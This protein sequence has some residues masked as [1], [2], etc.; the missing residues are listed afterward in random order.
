MIKN[1]LDKNK[2]KK[3]AGFT[4][5]EILVAVTI[6]ASFIIA[7]SGVL[8]NVMKS[9]QKTGAVRK[10]Q[11]DIRYIMEAISREARTANGVL[12]KNGSRTKHAFE[13][14][15]D[16]KKLIIFNTDIA[17]GD[18]ESIK[19]TKTIYLFADN[20]IKKGSIDSIIGDPTMKSISDGNDTI[21]KEVNFSLDQSEP[22]SFDLPPL[23][24]IEIEA[25]NA[26]GENNKKLEDSASIHL[27]TSVSPRNY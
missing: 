26:K 24:N 6:F 25:V 14:D 13:V 11:E 9:E 20:E 10:T 3:E 19:I 22:S 8:S 21:I 4:L 12:D 27:K 15:S 7:T 23:L 18:L 17:Q 5:V 16:G 2:I 1:K